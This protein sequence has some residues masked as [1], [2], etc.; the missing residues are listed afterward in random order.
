MF[1]RGFVLIHFYIRPGEAVL[2]GFCR[3]VPL[4]GA[5]SHRERKRQAFVQAAVARPTPAVVQGG[6]QFCIWKYCTEFVTAAPGHQPIAFGQ[7]IHDFGDVLQKHITC[8]VAEDV[9]GQ[10]QKIG[11]CR[12]HA[13][14]PVLLLGIEGHGL[15][16]FP[17]VVQPG[18]GI[19]LGKP[20]QHI[21]LPEIE[22]FLVL[23]GMHR[24][25]QI[26]VGMD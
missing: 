1:Q 11:I 5:Q 25:F 3:T 4:G 8:L 17:P 24:G 23:Q 26:Q 18:H 7:L 10:F 21:F 13:D 15:F 22:G 9:V 6:F 19:P 2:E 16:E 20:F 14:I 12:Y